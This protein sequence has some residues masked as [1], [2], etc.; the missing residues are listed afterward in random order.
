MFKFLKKAEGPTISVVVPLYNHS[1]YIASALES[2]LEQTSPADEII[3]IDDGSTDN[4]FDIAQRVLAKTPRACTFR[5]ENAGAHNTINRAIGISRS[6]YVAVLNSDDLFA[7]RKLER[8]RELISQR[9]PADLIAGG[10]GIMD[11]DGRKQRGGVAVDWLARSRTFL[12]QFGLPQLSL[13]NENYVATTSNMV[14]SRRLWD[15]SGGFQPL[16]YCHDLDFLM[17][18]FEFGS[19]IL[20]LDE[21]HIMYRVHER[22][23]IKEDLSRVRVEIAAV[24]AEALHQSGPRLLSPAFNERDVQAFAEVMK[25]KQLSDMLCFFQTVRPAF[26]AR[27]EFY[28]YATSDTLSTAFRRI[29]SPG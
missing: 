18:A 19:V 11:D 14:F 29:V 4:G 27:G 12:D 22:N 10:V 7:R 6:E 3:L 24:I 2:V 9:G 1:R 15:A 21:E 5:Q 25:N 13:I 23:T 28:G 8:C 17:F 26:A 16:R 20:D